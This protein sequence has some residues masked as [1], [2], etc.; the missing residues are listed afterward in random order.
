MHKSSILKKTVL[1]FMITLLLGISVIPTT[2]ETTYAQAPENTNGVQSAT[3]D[4]IRNLDLLVAGLYIARGLALDLMDKAP[5]WRP[6]EIQDLD[7]KNKLDTRQRLLRWDRRP[8]NQILRDGF[9]PQV[10]QEAPSVQETDLYRYVDSNTPSIFVS[11]TKTRY[12]DGKRQQPWTP[13]SSARGIVYQYEI[14]APGGIDVNVFGDQSPWPNQIEV[15]FPGGIRPEFIRSVRELQDGRIQRVWI[16]PYFSD[17]GELEGIAA[18]SRTELVNWYPDH[19]DGNHKDADV[20]DKK[21]KNTSFN[22]DNDMY[23][24]NG[25]V[26]PGDDLSTFTGPG[27]IP[28]GEYQIKSKKDENILADLSKNESG[29]LV[30]ASQNYGFNNQKWN[31]VYNSSKD[32]YKIKSTQNQNLLLTWNSKHGNNIIGYDDNNYN[33]QYWKIEI[34]SDGYYKFRSLYN[35]NMLLDLHSGNTS[36]GTPLF[37][38]IENGAPSQEWKIDKTQY[39]PLKDGQYQI[40]SSI[41]TN[42]IADLSKVE[43]GAK[44]HIYQNYSLDNQKWNFTFDSSKQ[45]Y[46]ITIPSNPVISFAWDSNRSGKIIGAT[47]DYSDQYWRPEKTSDGYF[48]LRNYKNPKMVLDLPEG[49]TTNGA[50]LQAYEYNGTKAQKWGITSVVNQTIE[51]GEY[52]ITSSIN[53]NKVADLTSDSKVVIYDKHFKNNQK[54]RFTFNKDKQAYRVVNVNNTDLAFAWDSNYSG[55]IIGATGDYSDQYWRPEKT[56]DGYFILRNYKNPKMVLDLPGRNTTNGTQLQAYEDNG[57]V[58]QIAQ[59]WSLQRVDVPILPDGTYNISS[60]LDYKKVIDKNNNNAIIWQY[61]NATAQDWKLE[62]DSNKK[63]YKI[64]NGYAQNLG[65]YY[66]GKN[67]NIAVDNIDSPP[68][69]NE[70]RKFWIVEYNNQHGAFSIRSAY[71]PTQVLDL[72]DSSLENGNN[73]ISYTP[74]LNKNQL[75]NFMPR[76]N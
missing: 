56:S 72:Q 37:A 53:Q 46:K 18:S 11:T 20:P 2:Q 63:A 3:V 62:Y 16:N 70:L 9:I 69:E 47:G 29:S 73:I 48:I 14:F 26:P 71:D 17:P 65:L 21:I 23:G 27:I 35:T 40:K 31:F 32:A 22:P 55:K 36:D 59:K 76:I 34:T 42:K 10:I 61:I 44:I 66:Q 41:D 74:N 57:T 24:E 49:N 7:G 60:K 25:T 50:Q 4:W 13:R 64:R 33:D 43:D 28:D 8:P 38:W 45:A 39:Q 30:H 67:L 58:T 12:K 68:D 5:F 54:W 6:T 19:P 51:D 75:W 15:A 52:L 1:I